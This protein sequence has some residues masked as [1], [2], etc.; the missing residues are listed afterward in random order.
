MTFAVA[1]QILNLLDHDKE[2][3]IVEDSPYERG[4]YERVCSFT[5]YDEIGD[6]MKYFTDPKYKYCTQ[7]YDRFL[8]K[9]I[10]DEGLEEI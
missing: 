7:D 4:E 8:D 3:V 6:Y 10:T 9:L 1:N 5:K 2:I